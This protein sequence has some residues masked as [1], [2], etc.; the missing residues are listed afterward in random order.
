M[1]KEWSAAGLA[2]V[3][4]S[5]ASADTLACGDKFL[6]PS[7]GMR[8]ELKPSV[9][10]EASVLVY[11][12]S[13]SVSAFDKSSIGPALRKAGYRPAV[14]G[15]VDELDRT[16]RESTWDVVVLDLSGQALVLPPLAG[17]PAVLAFAADA[18]AVDLAAAKKQYDTI[19]KTPTRSQTFVDAIDVAV[20]TRRAAQAKAV[21]GSK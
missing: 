21:K 16:L 15:S 6:V 4:G 12:A 17:S 13:V 10:Q 5:M 1:K 2:L 19:L 9:R 11:L 14:I 20:A 8:F 7:R 18:K 3:I